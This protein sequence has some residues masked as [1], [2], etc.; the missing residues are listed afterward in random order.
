MYTNTFTELESEYVRT[1]LYGTGKK[2]RDVAVV[3]PLLEAEL[4][5]KAAT[6]LEALDEI[7]N[8]IR[9][10][11]EEAKALAAVGKSEDSLE[12]DELLNRAKPHSELTAQYLRKCYAECAEPAA[13]PQDV[14][15]PVKVPQA[16]PDEWKLPKFIDK[17][18]KKVPDDP[19]TP[20]ECMYQYCFYGLWDGEAGKVNMR[21]QLENYL[22]LGGSQQQLEADKKFAEKYLSEARHLLKQA[23]K[24]P[25]DADIAA[26]AE[27]MRGP[28]F[29]MLK[30]QR[31]K[32]QVRNV[33][34]KVLGQHH[35]NI[36]PAAAATPPSPEIR[37]AAETAYGKCVYSGHHND[38]FLLAPAAEWELYV[39]E[40]GTDDAFVTGGRGVLAGVLT[41]LSRRLP[42]QPQ[43]HASEDET[44]EKMRSGDKVIQ[45]I[46]EHPQTGVLAVPA[47]AYESS[48]GWGEMVVSLID[49]VLRMLPL[50]GKATKLTVFVEGRDPYKEAKDFVF[51]RD[52]CRYQLARTLP[53]RAKLI[54]LD[55]QKMDKTH[56]CNAYPDLVSHTCCMRSG[57]PVA[58]ERFRAANWCGSCFLNYD[59]KQ[60]CNLLDCYHS[61]RLLPATDWDALIRMH[62]GGNNFVNALL[63]TFGEEARKDAEVWRRLLDICLGHLD[64]KAINLHKLG[65]Q[66]DFLKR[67]Q[68]DDDALPPRVRLLWLTTKLAEANHR[69]VAVIEAEKEF[70]DLIGKLY[71]EDAPLTSFAVLHLA[72]A[73]TNAYEFR[74]ANELLEAYFN[75]LM[76]STSGERPDGNASPFSLIFDRRCPHGAMAIPGLKYFAQLVSSHGQHEAF[77]GRD[78]DAVGFFREAIDRFRRL[79]DSKATKR[80][81]DQTSAYL[82]TSLMDCPAPD[83]A[84]LAATMKEYFGCSA[85]DAARQLAADDSPENKYRHHI[86]LRLIHSG[87]AAPEVKDAYLAEKAN[88]AFSEDGHPWEMIAFYRALLLDDRAE[89]IEWL[90]KAFALTAGAD[91]TLHVIGAV[92]LGALLLDDE[93]VTDGYCAL[94]ERCAG[95]LPALGSRLDVL[96]EQPRL[97]RP[98]LELAKLVL[99]FNF[100]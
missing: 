56:P 49:L 62:D 7:L 10:F 42:K 63:Q 61:G 100:R 98:P 43:L 4:G 2:R 71:E 50:G 26:R 12:Y 57:N 55:I 92:I 64:S 82:L 95:E 20:G 11:G 58:R 87:K 94:V 3:K 17:D 76:L 89:R 8:E 25:G 35:V 79:S 69:G 81:I 32:Q 48:E 83:E 74:K 70:M 41:D 5:E 84:L 9:N 22:A 37:S 28:V 88:W 34:Q 90:Q 53:E 1:R 93:S 75:I 36:R 31:E 80:D 46:L 33:R 27:K 72:V 30:K 45:T 16:W 68:P 86:L 13:E 6:R 60:L 52:A 38:I 39:D 85:V 14:D 77:L 51:M 40:S 97:K 78:E 24:A 96:R 54:E 59:A 19:S 15:V 23:V 66:I 29:K 99:P 73:R 18:G 21:Q 47:R 91:A 44:E 67:F 65:R